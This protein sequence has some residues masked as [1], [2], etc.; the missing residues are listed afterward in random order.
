MSWPVTTDAALGNQDAVCSRSVA[1]HHPLT[2][3]L[4]LH[5]TRHFHDIAS[6]AH[7]SL[8]EFLTNSGHGELHSRD[9]SRICTPVLDIV[10]HTV[11]HL[12][13]HVQL[14]D[15]KGDGAQQDPANERKHFQWQ[16]IT[17]NTIPRATFGR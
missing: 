8:H 16:S 3:L 10:L 11:T 7:Y 5:N 14:Y 17:A 9:R 15:Q 2:V 1:H 13:K 6:S 12:S 4:R